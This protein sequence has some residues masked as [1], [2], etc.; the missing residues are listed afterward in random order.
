MTFLATL[1]LLPAA[2]PADDAAIKKQLVGSWKGPD[3]QTIVVK[4]DGVMTSS[5]NPVPEKWD[6]LDGV[7]HTFSEGQDGGKTGE[8]FFKIIS[9][10]KTTFVI[11]DKYHGQH[12]GTWARSTASKEAAPG[13]QSGAEN[14]KQPV[15]AEILVA[16]AGKA[17]ANPNP[18]GN[19]QVTYADGTKD[20]WT[21]KGNCSLA[22]VRADG[23]V[24]WTV[25]GPETQINSA[26]KMRPNGTLILC[27]RGKV[28]AQIKS[29]KN[30][31][32]KWAFYGDG[33]QLVL[34]TRGSHGPA[35]IELHDTTTGKLI[36]SVKEAAENLPEWAK[37]YAD[38]A[39]GQRIST[40]IRRELA[41]NPT[42][43]PPSAR[44]R[45]AR[46]TAA[47]GLCIALR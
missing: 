14:T 34:V 1:S 33:S 10:T 19:V 37:P 25:H 32:E 40:I 30:Y 42:Q 43:H 4:E 28:I 22:L 3:G 21:T 17:D 38:G 44:P 41:D 8:N 18:I 35:D 20:L 2:A 9:L 16:N 12:T 46:F 45:E 39:T 29:A 36:A 7:F 26:D 6:V 13:D 27:L 47:P 23:T 15:S 31:I 5:D 24:G 11:Q